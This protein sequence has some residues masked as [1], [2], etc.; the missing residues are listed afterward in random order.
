MSVVLG[1]GW[2]VAPTPEPPE[3]ILERDPMT[4]AMLN[5]K[6]LLEQLIA[7][8]QGPIRV[9]APPVDFSSL[10]TAL[11]AFPGPDAASIGQ[12]VADA[13][14]I[15]EPPPQDTSH[16]E[17]L[18]EAMN[19]LDFRMKGT[20]GGGSLSPDITDRMNRQLGHV[21]VDGTVR[22]TS[23][24]IVTESGSAFV[25]GIR[26]DIALVFSRDKYTSSTA[27]ITAAATQNGSYSQDTTNGRITFATGSTANHVVYYASSKKAV[28]EPGHTIRGEQTIELS[29]LPTGTAE[30]R[31]GYGEDDGSAGI[32]NGVGWGQDAS[33]LFVW[34]RKNGTDVLKVHQAAFNKDTLMGQAGSTF[35]DGGAPVAFDP[36]KNALFRVEFEWLGIAPPAFFIMAPDG[37]FVLAHIEETPDTQTG[38]TLPEPQLPLMIRAAND[39]MGALSVSSG[40]WRGGIYTSKIT[41]TGLNPDGTYTDTRATG[42]VT[43]TPAPSALTAGSTYTSDWH[44]VVGFAAIGLVIKTDQISGSNGVQLQFSKDGS[45]VFRTVATEFTSSDVTVG[46]SFFSVP[47]QGTFVRVVYTNGGT[48]QGSFDLILGMSIN[49]LEISRTSIEAT[50]TAADV[51]A[52]GRNALL[53]KSPIDNSY[54]NITRTQPDGSSREGLHVGIMKHDVSTPI[55][56]LTSWTVG[57]ATIASA[58]TAVNVI[59]SPTS[60]RKTFMVKALSSNSKTVFVGP[61]SGVTS[62]S[63]WELAAGEGIVIE[64]DQTTGCWVI[65]STSTAQQVCFIEVI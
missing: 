29:A 63:G 10:M 42:A 4:A 53:A 34:R 43:L 6:D 23:E 39:G 2:P 56:A 7:R 61:T 62:G 49:A 21:I 33:G 32:L 47:P 48:N 12:A 16:L 57:Q 22:T 18:L 40:S 27:G 26:D 64:V 25:E 3:A 36:S 51:A 13:I 41:T 45:T 1:S 15:P 46:S 31:W 19:K 59:P 55:L 44:D 17:A 54:G 9:E 24:A 5:V 58:T 11:Q 60:G 50:V 14:R 28:Y 52:L 37:D 30:V 8:E 65:G 35:V 20:G 38:T